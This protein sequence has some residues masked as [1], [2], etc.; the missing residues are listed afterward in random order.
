MSLGRAWWDGTIAGRKQGENARN[1]TGMGTL[2]GEGAR[3]P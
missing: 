2:H 3:L 1:H